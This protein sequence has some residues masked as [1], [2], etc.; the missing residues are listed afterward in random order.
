[1]MHEAGVAAGPM[2]ALEAPVGRAALGEH[3]VDPVGAGVAG[4]DWITSSS[5]GTSYVPS[6][7]GLRVGQRARGASVPGDH[8]LRLV[9]D[10]VWHFRAPGI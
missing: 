6:V 4:A 7:S 8:S 10:V 2:R 1:M 5:Y 9:G 3:P